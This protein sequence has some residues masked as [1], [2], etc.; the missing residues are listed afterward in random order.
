MG[1]VD[2]REVWVLP[3][4]SFMDQIFVFDC[5]FLTRVCMTSGRPRAQAKCRRLPHPP[6]K[7]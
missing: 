1:E 6:P 5:D 3:S 2:E 7:S 4:L